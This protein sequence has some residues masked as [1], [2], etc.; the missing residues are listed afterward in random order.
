MREK[1]HRF[2]EPYPVRYGASHCHFARTSQWLK[3]M[4]AHVYGDRSNVL[5]EAGMAKCLVF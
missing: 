4:V 3:L 2:A 5:I 1:G